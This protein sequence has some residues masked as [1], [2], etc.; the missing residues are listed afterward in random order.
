MTKSRWNRRV[1][2]VLGS[3]LCVSF[4]SGSVHAAPG[5]L[6]PTFGTGGKVTD[7]FGALVSNADASSVAIQNDGKIVAGGYIVGVPG[8]GSVDFALAR[9]NA[10]GS[11]DSSFGVG[12]K[13]V[14][15]FN[16]VSNGITKI[17]L[18]SDGKIVAGGYVQLDTGN[19]PTSVYAPIR[20]AFAR[21]NS[22][23]SLDDTFGANGK[24]V[25][26]FGHRVEFINSLAVQSDGK[27]VAAGTV[28]S[29]LTGFSFAVARYNVNG[30]LDTSFGT[31]GLTTTIFNANSYSLIR[32]VVLQSDGK[33]VV[34]GES[35]ADVADGTH[36]NFALARYNTNGTLDTTFGSGGKTTTDFNLSYEKL[37]RLIL[38][39]DGKIVA[40]GSTDNRSN[41]N[42]DD[43]ALARY[44]TNGAL[45]TT[46]GNGGKVV[47]NLNLTNSYGSTD[48]AYS[49][50]LQSDGKIVAGGRISEYSVT[51]KFALQRYNTDGTLDS[52]FGSGG[53]ITTGWGVNNAYIQDIA[54]QKDGQIVAVGRTT[55]ADYRNYNFV[56][57]RYEGNR[58]ITNNPSVSIGDVTKS[59]GNSGSTTLLF[60][61]TLSTSSTQSVSVN[62]ATANGTAIAGNS[63]PFDYTAR[64]GTVTFS[65]GQTLRYISVIVRG[66]LY[67]ETDDTFGVTLSNPTS[68][69]TLNRA[70][71][72]GTITND[73]GNGLPSISVQGV[74]TIEGNSGT[75]TMLFTFTLNKPSET[76][77]SF[78]FATQNGTATSGNVSPADYSARSG[79]ITFAP[80][81]T[82]RTVAI[83]I[84]GDTR[85]EANETFALNLSSVQGATLAQNF[86][87]GTI[88]NDDS[89][90]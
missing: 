47:T 2:A 32:S 45:D 17:V 57:A 13:V 8:T 38:Q 14:T 3:L 66:D 68:D 50:A 4:W 33:I 71:A 85:V 74:S 78:N 44:N 37:S 30:S 43:V 9:H 16:S 79:S 22:D 15:D 7:D 64:T 25:S 41:N 55:D 67:V 11:L 52:G 59:E 21:Y 48:N 5:D 20:F 62:F 6:D 89:V 24:V 35:E 19:E 86:A 87:T 90:I 39:S 40:G 88:N 46:F 1:G 81:Q 34:G 84:Y 77:I 10:D 42:S 75:K 61:V 76:P 82:T 26:D 73:D 69:A 80:G 27:I 18:Q 53:I 65:P 58:P 56:L 54:L 23:G 72:T 63:V 83:T 28:G 51:T 70:T 12:G 60:P 49:I 29:E 31:N 36:S